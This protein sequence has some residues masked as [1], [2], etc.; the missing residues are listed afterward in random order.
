[1]NHFE[2]Y[3]GCSTLTFRELPLT[4]AFSIIATAGFGA[5]DIAV[6]P[7]Y[8]PHIDPLSWTEKDDDVLRAALESRALRLSS[9]NVDPGPLLGAT[10]EEQDE[11]IGACIR[12][13]SRFHVRTVTVPPGHLSPRYDW[14]TCARESARRI[15]KLAD[16]AEGAGVRLSVEAPHV[17]TLVEDC[18]AAGRLFEI[19][20]D[21]RVGC[22]FDTSHAQVK[23]KHS[24]SKGI[25][26]VG[27]E[28]V[29]VHLRDAYMGDIAVTPGKGDCEYRPFIQSLLERGYEGDLNFELEYRDASQAYVRAELDYS[30]R[31]LDRILANSPLDRD[32]AIWRRKSYRLL[33]LASYAL[34]HPEAFVRARPGLIRRLKP[35][36]GFFRR[37][38]PVMVRRY[39]AGWHPRLAF[40]ERPS[41]IAIRPWHRKRDRTGTEAK[42]T[43]V[44][45]LGCGYTGMNMHGPGFARIPG[46]EVVG[47]CDIDPALADRAGRRLSCPPF[48]DMEEML[49]SARPNLVA[50]CTREWTHYDSTME[51]L[52]RG[53]DV[54][55][56]K[57]M[58]HE[59]GLGTEMVRK[60][61]DCGRT[62]GVNYNWRFLPGIDR[63][64]AIRDSGVLGELCALRLL[65]HS[66]VYHHSIDL[67]R[68]LG[69]EIVGVM[70]TVRDEDASRSFAPW[71]RYAGE[72]LYMPSVYSMVT[73]ET[74]AGVGASLLG[75]DLLDPEGCL[76]SLDAVFREGT[77]S[78]SGIRESDAVGQLTCSTRSGRVDL[79]GPSRGRPPKFALCFQRSIMAFMDAYANGGDVPTSGQDGLMVMEIEGAILESSRSRKRIAVSHPSSELSD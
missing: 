4:E 31:Y 63:I 23:S 71:N 39:E 22:T 73:L 24:L 56:E 9:L 37:V 48:Y 79:T 5:V 18:E 3:I 57:I 67:V 11:Y 72:M 38:V 66:W 42:T 59:I 12:I 30:K 16:I 14:E 32:Q 61:A 33:R 50:N 49:E 25:D 60:A 45:I 20:D 54:F 43:R 64:R 46:V 34:R 8:C 77:V 36:V 58:A 40:S 68:F 76:F 75:T 15:C 78:L 44:A 41:S 27:A 6:I 52:G 53:I 62:L 26:L 70:A 74:E 47:V 19:I 29:H 10:I 2:R 17:N 1:M 7:E 21:E 35:V 69:G 65:S 28:I 13:G 55:C 51:M